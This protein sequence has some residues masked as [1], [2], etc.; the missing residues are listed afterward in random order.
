MNKSRNLH[1][2]YLLPMVVIFLVITTI[3]GLGLLYSAG[4]ERIAADRRLYREQAFYLAEA[5]AQR[6][7]VYLKEGKSLPDQGIDV[8]LGEGTY[9]VELTSQGSGETTIITSTGTVKGIQET[10]ELTACASGG[11]KGGKNSWAQGLFGQ[12]SVTLYNNAQVDS[13]DSTLGPYGGSNVGQDGDV[14][15]KGSITLYDSSTV[16]GDTFVSGGP[17]SITLMTGASITGDKNYNHTFGEPLDDLSQFPVVI[18]GTLTS[19][20][21]PS[22]GDPRIIVVSGSYTL[23]DGV[24]ILNNNARITITGGNFRFKSITLNNNSILTINSDS[25]LYLENGFT[26]NN[27][28]QFNMNASA[29]TVLYLGNNVTPVLANN[30]VINNQSNVPGNFRIYTNSSSPITLANNGQA[31][32]SVLYAPNASVTLANN[33]QFYGGIVA[34]NVTLYQNALLHYDVALRKTDFPDDPWSGGSTSQPP[35]IIRWRKPNWRL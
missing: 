12:Q 20:P 22:Y 17:G 7:F 21:Y 27:N 2:G 4:L 10:V 34:K 29:E 30:S 16:K 23:S 32:N 26:M 5:G 18:P 8:P 33:S 35:V 24:F 19:L 28:S 6:A 25:N 3:V 14:G 1:K 31:L 13:Y 15:S 9:K 11:N